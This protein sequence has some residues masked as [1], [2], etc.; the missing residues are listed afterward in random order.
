[1]LRVHVDKAASAEL[2]VGLDQIVTEGARRM[3]AAA[4]EAE[5]DA[6][7]SIFTAEVDEDGRRLVVRNGHAEQF[8]ERSPA[9]T[10]LPILR[11]RQQGE[12]LVGS[13]CQPRR[14]TGKF[15]EPSELVS[16]YLGASAKPGL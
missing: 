6:Y 4:L 3:L 2:S 13:V 16:S 12:I 8:V 14:Y 7:V 11:S 5:V 15:S 10:L 9:P 1:M